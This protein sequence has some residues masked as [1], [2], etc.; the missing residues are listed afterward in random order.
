MINY[1]KVNVQG[2]ESLINQ[3]V[4]AGVKNNFFISSIKVN[5][6]NSSLLHPFKDDSNDNP[7]DYYGISK[8][9][10]E[11]IVKLIS[12]KEEIY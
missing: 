10:A 6:E 12:K 8:L 4:K 5:G 1:Y 7:N 3:A 9:F 2:T 11:N